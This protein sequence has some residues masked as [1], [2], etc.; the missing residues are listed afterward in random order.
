[1]DAPDVIPAWSLLR[2]YFSPA[3]LFL[4]LNV[5]IG[6]IAL[7]SRRRHNDHHDDH[8]PQQ[9][10]KDYVDQYDAAPPAPAP[11]A[12]TSSVM[13]RLRSLGLY[14]FR[15]GDFPP[16]YNYNLSA[17][18][19]ESGKHHQQQAQYARSR[20]E[21]AAAKPPTNRTGNGAEKAA[22]AK[23]AKKP[24]SEVKRER[25]PAPAPARL[26]QRAPRA[27]VA[28]A[29]V[30]AAPEAAPEA[31]PAACV[32]ERADDFINKFRQQLQLQRLNSLL[33]YKEM[34]NGGT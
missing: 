6:T 21:P 13:E 5:V 32:D 22:K 27:P 20:S 4:L 7:T 19:D 34:L 28:R 11:L 23:V 10:Q 2:G 33:N 17:G 16:E 9:H 26:V 31:A 14:R 29:V 12:R 8:H 24:L 15:S 18:E 1:M 30:T 25:A 3:T